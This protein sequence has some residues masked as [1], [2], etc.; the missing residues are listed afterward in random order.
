MRLIAERHFPRFCRLRRRA[1][2]AT[3]PHMVSAM[4]RECALLRSLL[5]CHTGVE[6][7]DDDSVAHGL[8]RGFD[9]VV[10]DANRAPVS[11]AV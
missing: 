6:E 1:A 9:D 2:R 10:V 7:A 11:F 3:A 4:D 8:P 5:W